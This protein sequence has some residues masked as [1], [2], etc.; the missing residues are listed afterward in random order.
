MAFDPKHLPENPKVLQQMVLDLIAQLD[1]E[2]TE[3][4]KIEALL[5]EPLNARRNRKSEQL[6]S[7]QLAL[8]A[9]DWQ[10]RQAEAEPTNPDGPQILLTSEAVF[11]LF[12]QVMHDLL[13]LEMPRKRLTAAR[14]FLRSRLIGARV[15]VGVVVPQDHGRLAG[16]ELPSSI[17]TAASVKA[18]DVKLP[19]AGVGRTASAA[20]TAIA[21]HPREVA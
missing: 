14:P 16:T 19:F 18:L 4:N 11:F 5:R 10:A 21:A 20:P 12:R 8:F 6:S 9:A 2:C 15:S 1:R 13:S 3:G 17:H 7:D